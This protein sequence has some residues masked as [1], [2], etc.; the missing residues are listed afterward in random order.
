MTGHASISV[1]IQ[2]DEIQ[3]D[4]ILGAPAYELY[5]VLATKNKVDNENVPPCSSG[6]Y[7]KPNSATAEM[8]T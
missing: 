5:N 6:R 1:S 2:I 8:E 7:G 4:D 3:I